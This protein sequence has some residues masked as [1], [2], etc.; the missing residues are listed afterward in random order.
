MNLVSR[1][2]V[3]LPWHN[4]RDIGVVEHLFADD[5]ATTVDEFR[6]EV[7]GSGGSSR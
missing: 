2:H 7:G 1:E 5:I 3:D 6:S 4:D